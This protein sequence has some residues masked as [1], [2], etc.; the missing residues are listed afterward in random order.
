MDSIKKK[1]Q[2]KKDAK[3]AKTFLELKQKKGSEIL[4]RLQSRDIE[5]MRREELKKMQ[6]KKTELEAR[7]IRTAEITKEREAKIIQDFRKENP[8]ISQ[9]EFAKLVKREYGIDIGQQEPLARVELTDARRRLAAQEELRQR[10][11]PRRDDAAI[12]EAQRLARER[13]LAMILEANR[14]ALERGARAAESERVRTET[15]RRLATAEAE[16][17]AE[18]A[19]QKLAA[20]EALVRRKVAE[21]APLVEATR[22]AQMEKQA[23]EQD[24]KQRLKLFKEFSKELKRYEDKQQKLEETLTDT[25]RKY[26]KARRGFEKRVGGRR[27]EDYTAAEQEAADKLLKREEE[28]VEL[29]N[30]NEALNR[31]LPVLTFNTQLTSGITRPLDQLQQLEAADARLLGLSPIGQR[32][33]GVRAAGEPEPAAGAA[34]AAA[35][36]EPAAGAA[37]AAE[38]EEAAAGLVQ[39]IAQP[40][41]NIVVVPA[42]ANANNANALANIPP[43]NVA[44]VNAQ[45]AGTGLMRHL[46]IHPSHITET[47][48]SY[49]LTKK[50]LKHGRMLMK[51]LP[52]HAKKIIAFSILNKARNKIHKLDKKK[53]VSKTRGGGIGQSIVEGFV[54]TL[55]GNML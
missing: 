32:V 4:K 7:A 45:P 38:P 48:D 22:R 28:L 41:A 2:S 26:D 54:N 33:V 31:V 17:R 46:S 42:D 19:R 36:P 34:A 49:K 21:Q 27:A 47:A 52:N 6:E 29:T 53:G 12:A 55:L 30:R 13:E 16:R 20:E 5:A 10:A 8:N 18:A 35:E 14:A 25:R 23:K 43:A 11:Q 9:S 15:Q 44:A 1:K 24:Q 51:Y 39:A 37:A 3:K 50:G 40:P